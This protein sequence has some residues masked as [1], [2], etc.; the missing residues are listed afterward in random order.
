MDNFTKQ[1]PL[2][3]CMFA[4]LCGNTKR[5]RDA[6]PAHR[7]SVAI[8]RQSFDKGIRAATGTAAFLEVSFCECLEFTNWQMKLA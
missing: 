8:E 5:Y 6:S 7:G 2:K 1:R 3:S 4:G